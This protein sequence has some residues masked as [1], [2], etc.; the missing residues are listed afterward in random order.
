MNIKE[1]YLKDIDIND[2]FFDSLK[3]DYQ[4]FSTWFNKKQQENKKVYV[5]YNNDKLTSFL[6]LK[7][8]D[9]KEIYE[10][11]FSPKKRLKISTF[12]VDET[13]RGIGTKFIEIINKEREKNNIEETY[14]TI[15]PKYKKLIKFM[16]KNGFRYYCNKDK[17]LVYLKKKE[18][19]LLPVKP[20][21]ANKILNGKKKYEYRKTK[22]KKDI[23]K[24][25]IYST[26]PIKKIIGEVQ[27]IKIIELPK[28]ELWNLTKNSSGINKKDY[29]KYFEKQEKAVA[30]E[31]GK[32]TSYEKDLSD[33]G[34]CF[35]PQSYIYLDN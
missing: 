35:T 30:Y 6:L 18:T 4:N 15:Y 23:N 20:I 26:S 12:K 10:F 22:P 31:L 8:E 32:V 11:N 25:I 33:I 5:T 7:L 16:E 29:D 24:I 27:V 9:E 14:F 1:V 3:E 19:I 21:Y 2:P 28:E 17:E 13:N 34:I